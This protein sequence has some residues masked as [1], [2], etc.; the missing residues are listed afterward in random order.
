MDSNPRAFCVLAQNACEPCT[1]NRVGYSG[2]FP[3]Q[4][5]GE[6][7]V[8]VLYSIQLKSYG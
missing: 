8:G 2:G 1:R 6:L 4:Q 7:S 5:S 3:W